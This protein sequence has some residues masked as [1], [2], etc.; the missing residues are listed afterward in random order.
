MWWHAD[1]QEI[2]RVQ[3]RVST[4]YVER[5]HV[6]RDENAVVFVNKERTVRLPAAMI[7]AVLL[8]PGSR[9]THGAMSLLGDSGSCVC[10]VGEHGV[11]MYAAGLGPAR[12][13]KWFSDRLS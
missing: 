9:V 1:A 3:D 11:R 8:G 13:L 4:I 10:W 12:A 5:C 2:H 6:D 7:G